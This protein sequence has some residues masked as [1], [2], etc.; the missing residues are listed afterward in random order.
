MENQ[1][2]CDDIL[3]VL[4]S[5]HLFFGLSDIELVD[6]VKAVEMYE[7]ERG[8]T[9]NRE[10]EKS[11]ALYIIHSGK[12]ALSKV[13]KGKASFQKTLGVGNSWGENCLDERA[14][15]PVRVIA[16]TSMLVIRISREQLYQLID[17]FPRL[18]ANMQI[19]DGSSRLQTR[20]RLPWMGDDEVIF[21]MGRKHPIFLI[22][23]LLL[24]LASMV[25]TLILVGIFSEFDA[26]A[27]ASYVI[28]GMVGF[29]CLLWAGWNA[30]DWSNDYS[31]VT[32][33]RVIWLERTWGLFDTRV[34]SPLNR[35]QS[36]DVQTTQAG[37][38]FGYGNVIVR[39]ITGPL[40]LPDVEYPE[41]VAALIQQHWEQ[42]RLSNRQ[43]EREQ[44]TSSL[45]L[46][47]TQNTESV[48]DSAGTEPAVSESMEPGFLQELFADFFKVRI[49]QNGVVTYRKHWFVL[50]KSTWKPLLVSLVLLVIWIIRMADGFEF[51][52]KGGTLGFLSLLWFGMAM[53]MLYTYWDWRNDVYQITPEQI[54]DLDKKPFGTEEKKIA[55]LENILSIQYKRLGIPG[56]LFNFG[57]VSISV[58]TNQFTF[59]EVYDP[60]RVQA[61]LFRRMAEKQF[62]SKQTEINEERER[63]SDWIATYHEHQDEF[64][65]KPR[66]RNLS[67]QPDGIN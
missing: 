26:G 15:V 18:G 12:A 67:T 50:L 55:Q 43:S 32:N 37:R 19:T 8:A 41:D 66:S 16:I 28:G 11:Q 21:Y 38:I 31:I 48:N 23:R 60:S 54:I 2:S 22:T 34:E 4:R 20:L 46:R 61:D 47:L 30:L 45:R 3:Q 17:R 33:L 59:D 62:R 35:M 29:G 6:V 13:S 57:T 25:M 44:M 1:I 64:R 49:E 63:V 39:T 52:S 14:R 42:S 10:G 40:I 5:N 27:E 24:P 36:V 65:S 53:W 51:I 56:I 7:V 9:I 58:G